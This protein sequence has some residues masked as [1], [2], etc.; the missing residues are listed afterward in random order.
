[1]KNFKLKTLLLFL[2]T[3]GLTGFFLGTLTLTFPVRWM[4]NYAEE[5]GLSNTSQ[6]FYV[7]LIIGFFVMTTL[8]MAYLFTK[9]IIQST[10]KGFAVATLTLLIAGAS[11]SLYY[12][13]NPTKFNKAAMSDEFEKSGNVEF[14]FGSYPDKEMLEDLKNKN[15]TGVISLLHPAVIPFEPK[16]IE[17]EKKLCSKVGIPFISA[18]M[19]PWVSDNKKSLD[20]ILKLTDTGKGKYYVHCYL[21]VDRANLVKNFISKSSS[22]INIVSTLTNTGRKLDTIAAFE[23]GKIIKLAE[24][25]YLTPFPTDEEYISFILS[26]DVKTVVSILNPENPDDTLWIHKEE[27][28]LQLYKMN[29][30]N[31]PFTNNLTAE[32]VESKLSKIVALQKPMVIHARSDKSPGVA[33]LVEGYRKRFLETN[34]AKN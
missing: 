32:E 29:Y 6:D 7:K 34:S 10:G 20:E 27:K 30:V 9:K 28:L 31:I 33:Q 25:I 5:Q 1:M 4:V 24:K 13:M 15:F 17:D 12:W 22:N 26:T 21:G 18:P 8:L 19:L 2:T 14:Y 3:A 11:G 23:R 16:L